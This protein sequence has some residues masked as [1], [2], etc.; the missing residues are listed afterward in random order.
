[1]KILL[2]EDEHDMARVVGVALKKQGY[3]VTVV[4]NGLDAV[5]AT[6]TQSFNILI[7]DVMMPELDGFSALKQIRA[8]GNNTYAI[9]LTAKVQVEDKVTGFENGADDYITKPFSLKELLMRVKSRERRIDNF[10]PHIVSYHNTQLNIDDQMLHSQND[11]SLSNHETKTLQYLLSNAGKTITG[12]IL[13]D[14][15]DDSTESLV[16]VDLII[17]Y[18]QHKLKSISSTIQIKKKRNGYVLQ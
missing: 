7:L 17:S 15:L 3:H 12:Q 8:N 14:N 11:I 1:M 5:K 13:L 2:A 6:E 18:L 16:T 9:M 4:N 10:N